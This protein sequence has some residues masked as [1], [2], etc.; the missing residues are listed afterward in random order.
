MSCILK[1]GALLTVSYTIFG[2]MGRS[3]N[4]GRNSNIVHITNGLNF[5]RVD[6]RLYQATNFSNIQVL[7]C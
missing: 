6:G 2:N 5:M 4:Y 1:G 3:P 7:D